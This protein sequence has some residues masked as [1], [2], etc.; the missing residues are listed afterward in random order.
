MKTQPLTPWKPRD[1]FSAGHLNES[2]ARHRANEISGSGV[3]TRTLPNGLIVSVPFAFQAVE[4]FFGV[5]VNNGPGGET[6]DHEDYWVQIVFIVGDKYGTTV[7]IQPL[8][9]PGAGNQSHTIVAATNLCER[10]PGGPKNTGTHV[11]SAGY[12]VFIFPAN[13]SADAA[14]S[15]SDGLNNPVNLTSQRFVFFDSSVGEP[16]YEGQV[17]QAVG[18]NQ[19]AWKMFTTTYPLT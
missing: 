12:P 7:D 17:D 10:T 19:R 14:G 8:G 9:P 1:P 5:I 11:L 15:S 13:G 4:G 18:N 16:Q 3:N 2:V 6:A